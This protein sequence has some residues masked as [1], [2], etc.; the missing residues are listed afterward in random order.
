MARTILS[1][2]FAALLIPGPL[3][4]APVAY[5]LDRAASTVAFETAFG[6]DLI[7]GTIPLDIA[8]LTLDFDSV[9]NCTVAVQL[10]VS[11]AEASFPF[12]AQALKGPKVLDAVAHP[13]MVF[14]STA[15]K[16]RGDGAIVAGNLTIRGVTRP[17]QLAAEI[18]R[19]KG[20]VEGDRS[21]LTVRLTGKINRS[22]FGAT[23][24]SD[25]VDDAVRIIITARI[26]AKG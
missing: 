11:G 21:R 16:A 20:T 24:W 18:F 17:V 23:G 12:A 25:M 1:T 7:T 3:M 10:D 19:Q 9:A 4:A 2:L 15:V 8:D 26:E 14:K 22:D 5:L 6:P 13:K